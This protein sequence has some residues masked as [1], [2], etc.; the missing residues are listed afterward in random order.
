MYEV[1]T[2]EDHDPPLPQRTYDRTPYCSHVLYIHTTIPKF[3]VGVE[4]WSW[5]VL[6]EKLLPRVV[7]SR[8]GSAKCKGI[9]IFHV[10][11]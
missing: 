4:N 10:R 2:S 6:L 7:L 8:T 5:K 1:K 3:G 11:G 9:S